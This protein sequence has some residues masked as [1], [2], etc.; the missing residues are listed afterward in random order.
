M[1]SFLADEG[2]L[3]AVDAA[4][5][6][7]AL[8]PDQAAALSTLRRAFTVNALPPAAA[9]I[10]SELNRLEAA[11][12]QER[13]SMRLGWSD[14]A[15][16]DFVPASSVQLRTLMRTS[17]DEGVRRAAYEGL[18]SVGPFVAER[19]CG[20]VKRRNALARACGATNFYDYKVRG[21]EGMSQTDLFSLLDPLEADTCPLLAAARASLAVAK[22]P[23][24][25]DPW[26]RAFALA[27]DVERAQDPYYRFDA[28]VGAWARSFAALGISY[29]GGTVT[30]DLCDRPGKYSNG[31]C[32]WP[33]LAWVKESG[34]RALASANFTSLA[35]PNDVGSGRTALTTLMHEG[36]HAA[37]FANVAARTPLASQERAPTS[38]AYAETQS[39]FL[40]SLCGDAAWIARY[41]RDG[42]G[43]PVPWPLVEAAIRA[44]AAGELFAVRAMLSVPYF[45]KA[46]Y[47]L[48]ESEVTP[49]RV[50]ALA[51]EVETLIEGG[52]SPRPLLSVPHVLADESAAYYHGYVLAEMAVH[53][54]RAAFS[55]AFGSVV[56]NPAVGP[57]LRD[58]YWAPGNAAPFP[59]LVREVTGAPLSHGAW[60]AALREPVEDRVARERVAYE[61]A[62]VKGPAIAPGDEPA[63]DARVRFVHGDLVIA[64]SAAGG[65]AAAEAAFRAWLAAEFPRPADK[66]E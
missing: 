23:A 61:E 59:D 35:S 17:P 27:G 11:L 45:E 18:R 64:D 55:K 19:L 3:A 4:L 5:A 8:S 1:E 10:R 20:I 2:N 37:H 65:F 15:S 29:A 24:A 13:G 38:V 34:E 47:D 40:D 63:I 33:A 49:E 54:T 41:A 42:S 53:A 43:A 58:G 30:L 51:D 46:L 31:F 9:P 57:A 52:A 62:V 48:P 39:M 21:A 22:G 66:A 28:A 7:R 25:N 16:G 12:A 14:P 6:T 60:V 44:G 56:D 26:N 50:L 32:H 36:G